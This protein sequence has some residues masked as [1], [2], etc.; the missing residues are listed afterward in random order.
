MVTLTLKEDRIE[1]GIM[2]EGHGALSDVELLSDY[3]TGLALRWG[4]ARFYSQFYG[5]GFINP[6]PDRYE[7]YTIPLQEHSLIDLTGVPI[8]GRD[9][10]FFTPPPFCFVLQNGDTR[11]TLGVAAK[12]GKHSF[13][14][15]V[16]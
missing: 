1:Y 14:S 6:E 7:Q 16:D 8:S 3:Y 11:M 9:H 5:D 13:A 15:P 4:N 2:L 10:W 12:P